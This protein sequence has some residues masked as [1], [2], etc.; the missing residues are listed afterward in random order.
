MNLYRKRFLYNSNN[1]LELVTDCFRLKLSY[2]PLNR[3]QLF[4]CLALIL[5]GYYYY[6]YY[7]YYCYYY[8]CYYYYYYYYYYNNYYYYY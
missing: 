8:Y 6:Y 4:F 5:L 1:S 2:S 7:Y 3:H